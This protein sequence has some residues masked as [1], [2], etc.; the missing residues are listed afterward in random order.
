M[1]SDDGELDAEARYLARMEARRREAGVESPGGDERRP[2][3]A[4]L[5]L[6]AVPVCVLVVVIA[7]L[8]GE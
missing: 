2:S 3:K 8:V 1:S 4:T 6:V 5:V 7:R